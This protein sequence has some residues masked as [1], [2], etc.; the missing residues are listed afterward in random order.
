MVTILLYPLGMDLG[1]TD[2]V[3]EIQKLVL[4][5]VAVASLVVGPFLTYMVGTACYMVGRTDAI[6]DLK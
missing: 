4:T 6:T 3:A 2:S 1:T 5:T